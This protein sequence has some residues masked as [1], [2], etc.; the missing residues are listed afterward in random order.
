MESGQSSVVKRK[1]GR[2]S[3]NNLSVSEEKLTT[4]SR[5][6]SYTKENCI[7]CQK[8]GGKLHKVETKR[9]GK[10]MLTVSK[11]LGDKSFFRRI[12]TLSSPGDSIISWRC[13]CK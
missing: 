7:I 9:T 2:P 11:Q 6:E 8:S 12:N 1:A 13:D 10:L 3:I 5:S 4:R